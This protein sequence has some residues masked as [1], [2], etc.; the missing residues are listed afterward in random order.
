[1]NA[2]N[3]KPGGSLVEMSVIKVTPFPRA[4]KPLLWLCEKNADMPRLLPIAIGEFEAAAIQIKLRQ[5]QP[6]VRP[7]SHDLLTT[8][9]ERLNADAR[10]IV[11]HSV[12]NSTFYATVVLEIEGVLHEVDARPSDAVAMGLRAK[13]PLYATGQI[14]DM[15]GYSSGDSIDQTIEDFSEFDPQI[16]NDA[17]AGLNLKGADAGVAH[18]DQ[19]ETGFGSTEAT[20]SHRHRLL[21]L[22]HLLEIAVICEEYEKAAELRDEIARSTVAPDS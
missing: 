16:V 6:P 11:I 21:L 5:D 7:I 2:C 9:L 12:H 17:G 8:M 15:A 20:H 1:M 3:S 14:L 4:E 22:R 10:R 18:S 19:R 13:A